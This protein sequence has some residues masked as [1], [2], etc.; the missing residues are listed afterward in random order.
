MGGRDRDQ[1]LFQGHAAFEVPIRHPGRCVRYT[2]EPTRLNSG[3]W[4]MGI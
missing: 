1:E 2:V 4:S 3:K